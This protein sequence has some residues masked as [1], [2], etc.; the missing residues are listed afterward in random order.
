MALARAALGALQD[1]LRRTKAD[2]DLTLPEVY[3]A[4]KKANAAAP[5]YRPNAGRQQPSTAATQVT[6]RTS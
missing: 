5:V 6:R 2:F 4:R 3:A 1:L